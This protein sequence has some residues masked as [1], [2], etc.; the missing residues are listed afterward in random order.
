MNDEEC[1]AEGAGYF[2][3]MAT[4]WGKKHEQKQF[5]P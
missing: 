5:S 4:P 3:P 1:S 2:S